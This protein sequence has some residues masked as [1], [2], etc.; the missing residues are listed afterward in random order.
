MVLTAAAIFLCGGGCAKQG[1]WR[2][3]DASLQRFEFT[4]PQMGVAF[5][6]VLYATNA[7]IAQSAAEAA[8]S[9]IAQLNDILSDYDTDSELNQLSRTA[10]EG[11]AVPLSRDLGRV[12]RAAQEM[13]ARSGGA[14]DVTVGPMVSLWRK[15]RREKKLPRAD[16]LADAQGA[17]GWQK[18]E[19]DR[20]HQTAK[21]LV[22]GMKLDLGGIA[23][24][25]ALDEAF[26]V[27]TA[28][29]VTRALVTAAGDMVAGEAPPGRRGWRIALAPLDATNAPPAEFVWLRNAALSTSGDLFQHVEID[30]KRYSHIVDPR[31]GLGL[32]DHSLV[33]VIAQDGTMADALATA[34]SVLGP[35]QGLKLIESTSGAAA[36]IVR[37]P[38]GEIQVKQ[39]RRFNRFQDPEEV[40]S[41]DSRARGLNRSASGRRN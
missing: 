38:N 9:R 24:G 14:F 3:A 25:Y 32:T 17:V 35:E 15:A 23:K 6:I 5:R 30:G 8:F 26:K 10:D 4:E 27:L 16:L 7:S 2:S 34:V 36:R 11:R 21:L 20:R 33:S 18:L 19:L 12:L 28:R 37:K 22:P 13:A 1:A 40:Q 39:S 31:T 41:E 29:G